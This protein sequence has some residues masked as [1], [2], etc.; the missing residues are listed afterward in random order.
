MKPTLA[1]IIPTYQGERV[2]E[3]CLESIRKFVP[4][5]E[6]IVS[7]NASTDRTLEAASRLAGVRVC[8]SPVNRGFGMA[9]NRGRELAQSELLFFLNQDTVILGSVEPVIEA[10]AA[11]DQLGV[12]GTRVVYPSGELQASIGNRITA[13]SV[14]EE[15]VGLFLRP[16]R[17]IPGWGVVNNRKGS[18]SAP[19]TCTWVSGCSMVVRAAVFDAVGGFS[20]DYFMYAEDVDLC[21]RAMQFGHQTAYHPILTVEHLER[22]GVRGT[23]DLALAQTI[24][25]HLTLLSKYRGHSSYSIAM[26]FLKCWFGMIGSIAGPLARILRSKRLDRVVAMCVILN[27]EISN[28]RPGTSIH[29]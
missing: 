25:G 29:T 16:L 28:M 5:V 12:I 1:I 2:L 15:W 27:R 4:D 7:D 8:T 14:C 13:L 6:V 19:H 3:A 9:C 23:S 11:D 26:G 17:R 22:S 10:F 21:L 24:R 18:Y 20:A